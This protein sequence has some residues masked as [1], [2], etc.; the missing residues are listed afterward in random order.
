MTGASCGVPRFSRSPSATTVLPRVAH[1]RAKVIVVHM[2]SFRNLSLPLVGAPMAGGPS[3]PELVAAVSRAGGLGMLAAGYLSPDQLA[4]KVAATRDLLADDA[5]DGSPAP[6]GVNLFV[7]NADIDA[8]WDDFHDRLA[9][10][11]PDVDL[12]E[13]PAWTDDEWIDKIFLLTNADNR[14]PVVTFTFGLPTVNVIDALHRVGTTLGA[15]VTNPR[16]AQRALDIGVDFLIVQ[17]IGAGGHQSTFTVDEEPE[18]MSTLDALKAVVEELSPRGDLP[19]IVAAGGVGTRD[20]VE[21]L[22]SAGATA[23]QVG[24]LLLTATEAGTRDAHRRALLDH[25]R[26]TVLTRC[27]SGRPARAL[28]NDF[29][30]AYTDIAPEAYPQLHYLTS[31]IRSAAAENGDAE[32]LNLWA[33]TGNANCREASA[34]D[35]LAD[36]AP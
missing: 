28:V 18:G 26:D 12:P 22:L 13:D 6:F 21:E 34:A 15:T 4:E 31:P 5:S 29:T 1:P 19:E 32:N 35:I 36:L 30:R 24:T 7:P 23:V 16:D 20:D 33:G 25:D 9:E 3:T 11:F 8:G 2:L 14:V 27:F 10:D 17:G